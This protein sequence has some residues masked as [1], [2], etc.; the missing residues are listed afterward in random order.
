MPRARRVTAAQIAKRLNLSRTTVSLALTGQ[1]QR[2]RIPD[3]TIERVLEAAREMDYHPSLVAQQ[4]AG[5]RSNVVGVLIKTEAIADVRLIQAMEMLA[6]ERGVRFIVGHAVGTHEKVREYLDDFQARGVDAVISIFHN[7]PAY[8]ET[9][10]AELKR[11]RHVV[12]YEKPGEAFGPEAFYVQP[13]YFEMGRLGVQHL[14]DRGRERIGLVFSNLVFPYAIQRRQAYEATLAKAGRSVD[15]GLIWALDERTSEHWTAPFTPE[16]ALQAVD[17]LV[18]ERKADGLVA[19]NDLY[20]ARLLGALRQRGRR[21]PEDVAVVGCD[22]LELGTLVT[23]SL[24]T[25]GFDID[26]LA[27]RMIER[28]FAGLEGDLADGITRAVVVQPELLIR[29]SG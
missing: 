24:T 18:V 28:L 26:E 19:V 1:G 11:F 27:E 21:A 25:L 4:L 15:E 29:E 14:I 20:A 5:K 16:L 22:N 17:A 7:H 13:D 8:C 9:V 10:L 3:R 2:H 6:A 23:P 12:F